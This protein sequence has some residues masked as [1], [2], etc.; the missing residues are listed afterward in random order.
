MTGFVSFLCRKVW[1]DVYLP[2]RKVK[3]KGEVNPTTKQHVTNARTRC[4]DKFA[5]SLDVTA[6]MTGTY[7]GGRFFNG[8]AHLK[9]RAFVSQ[10]TSV[11]C[12]ALSVC[13]C[14]VGRGWSSSCTRKWSPTGGPSGRPDRSQSRLNSH[15]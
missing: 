9:S 13:A 15:I 7:E 4:E 8:S 2:Y 12:C 6:E 10:S 14:I 1:R 3:I 5:R 11:A